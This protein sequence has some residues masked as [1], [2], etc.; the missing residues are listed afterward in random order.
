MLS[1]ADDLSGSIVFESVMDEECSG[2]GAGTLT[3]CHEGYTGDMVVVVDGGGSSMN[4][5]AIV[6]SAV[7]LSNV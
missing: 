6:W 3:C 5:T 4:D 1:V 7:T 2:S